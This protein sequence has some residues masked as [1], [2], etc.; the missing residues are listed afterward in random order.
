MAGCLMPLVSKRATRVRVAGWL[1]FIVL[2][3]VGEAMALS[4][5][6]GPQR[7]L[8]TDIIALLAPI[9]LALGA[10]CL[11][12]FRLGGIERRVWGLLAIACALLLTSEAYLTWYF[13][14]VDWR[15][16]QL[17]APFELLQLLS[18]MAFLMIVQAMTS[19]GGTSHL[20]RIRY[21]VD[22]AAASV[23]ATAAA[24][25]WLMLPL[26]LDV[27]S[28]GWPAAAV[29]APYLVLGA[30]LLA[31]VGAIAFGWKAY[32]WRAWER[33]LVGAMGLYAVGLMFV[34]VWY[35]ETLKA[36]APSEGTVL[37]S[38]LGFG[39]YL[40]FMAML[41]RLTSSSES[42]E[43]ERWPV[44]QVGSARLSALYPIALA[45]MLPVM[46]LASLRIGNLPEGGFI[47]A[48]TGALALLLIGRSWLGNL[49]RIHLRGLAITD[50]VTGSFNHRYLHERLAEA[51][52][53]LS[54][55]RLRARAR[56]LRYRRLR[57]REPG[58]GPPTRR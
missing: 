22:V 17:P 51:F 14:S 48:L 8:L 40:L 19:F 46:G 50:P 35:A 6:P 58:V 3:A 18:L 16:P 21:L 1:G 32:Q 43:L 12:T 2:V 34:P 7:Q 42:A 5:L 49:E 9:T 26:F 31:G 33:L 57:T 23:V 27:P 15:G 10:A 41:Y 24:Y 52:A 28:G 53:R 47:V 45:C 4:P 37:S 25:W 56:G 55:R 29:M 38:L 36:P 13:Y 20:S 54:G 11:L 39:F 30:L 44:P